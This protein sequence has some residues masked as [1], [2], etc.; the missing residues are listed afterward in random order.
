[1]ASYVCATCKG[2]GWVCEA[3]PDRPS[4]V[5]KENGCACGAPAQAC[6]CNPEGHCAFEAVHASVDPAIV[7][8]WVQ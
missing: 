3:H 1:M 6:D 8:E 5:A 4:A 7:K 2:S